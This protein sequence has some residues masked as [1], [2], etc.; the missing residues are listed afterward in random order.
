MN[1]PSACEFCGIILNFLLIIPFWGRFIRVCPTCVL[2][3]H[4]SHFCPHCFEVYN[5]QLSP[6]ARV[7][8]ITCS[9]SRH[10]ACVQEA[11]SSSSSMSYRCPRCS[12]TTFKFFDFQKKGSKLDLQLAKELQAAAMISKKLMANVVETKTIQMVEEVEK[13]AVANKEAKEALDWVIKMKDGENKN[14]NEN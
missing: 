5:Q 11:S 2:T 13:A 7:M 4:P 1:E 12:D 14:V 10:S 6:H 8:C 9:S 3:F